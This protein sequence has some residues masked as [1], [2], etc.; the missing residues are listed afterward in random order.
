MILKYS[1]LPL[2]GIKDHEEL[3]NITNKGKM[4]LESLKPAEKTQST[5]IQALSILRWGILVL[6]GL[7]KRILIAND[8]LG[9][10]VDIKV[11]RIRSVQKQGKLLLTRAYDDEKAY[12]IMTNML[13]I[14]SNRN[15]AAAFLP[16]QE[17]GGTL[18]DAMY[19]GDNEYSDEAGTI[20]RP[21][22]VN[23]QEVNA[24]LHQLISKNL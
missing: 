2:E 8:Q 9:S 18:S 6:I 7:E 20:L 24:I 1:Y 10:G 14:Q 11:L 3:Q 16:P 12:T 13:N 15:L 5:N 22:D 23:L 17:V 21:D 19:L 4:L